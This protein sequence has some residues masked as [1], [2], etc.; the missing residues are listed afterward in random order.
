MLRMIRRVL[1]FAGNKANKIR[2]AFLFSFLKS[3]CANM[4]IMLAI[5]TISLIIEDKM[6]P[7]TCV[8]LSIL[9]IVMLILQSVFQHISDRLQSGAGY[10][11][12]AEKR[13]LLGE[14]LRKLPMGFFSDNNIGKISSILSADM[15]FMEEN[16]MQVIANIISDLFS[17]IVLTIFMFFIHPVLGVV[18]VIT[19]ITAMIIAGFMN[20]ETVEDSA[21]RQQAIEDMTGAILEYTEGIGIIKSFNMA[22]SGAADL[23]KSFKNMSDV[24]IKFEK[25]HTPWHRLLLITYSAGTIGILASA[26]HLYGNNHLDTAAII[27]VLI[28]LFHAFSP[29]K[30]LYQQDARITI[31]NNGLDRLEQL[32]SEPE[33]ADTGIKTIPAESDVEIAFENVSFSYDKDEILHEINFDVLRGETV[34]LIGA[35]GS[36][37]TTIANLLARFWDVSEGQIKIRGVNIK[38]VS[39]EELMRHISM[40][41]QRVYLFQDTIYNN[42]CMGRKDATEEDVYEAAKKARCYD[43]IM[44]LPYGF[45]TVIGEGGSSLS[46]GEA[47]RIS[48]ARC[49]LKD[50]PIILLDEATASIDAD[51]ESYI[52]QAIY[53]L[54]KDKTTIVIAHKLGTIKNADKIIVIDKGCILEM[55]TH[56][57]LIKKKGLY[58]KMI[59]VR[60]CVSAWNSKE[61][62]RE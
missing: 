14:H 58:S 8:Y 22:G 52:Q 18:M 31:M 28:F 50:S 55:G 11:M 10:E 25:Q 46:G 20:R 60:E 49:I 4:P 59:S 19:E 24:N 15:V 40:V 37:K 21:L 53:E 39:N 12:F 34:A 6:Q 1:K 43:F 30:H 33:I 38:D 54:C 5:M 9:L 23:R 47:Q 27:G 2:L 44:K 36:G 26:I 56:N 42:I 62:V 41:F 3:V 35:S 45:Q 7:I 48:I 17:Q 57:E 29:I 51:N 61:A 32:F 16:S 13:M